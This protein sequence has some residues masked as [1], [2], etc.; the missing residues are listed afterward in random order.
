MDKKGT[1]CRKC[2]RFVWEEDVGKERLCCFCKEAAPPVQPTAVYGTPRK[3][4]MIKRAKP[5]DKKEEE[6]GDGF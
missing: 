3:L 6:E 2:K 1:T 4:K 5:K